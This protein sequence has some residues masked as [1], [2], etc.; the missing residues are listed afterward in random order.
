VIAVRAKHPRAMDAHRIGEAFSKQKVDAEIGGSV[1]DAI[2][3]AMADSDES[4][5]ICITGSLFVAAEARE[6]FGLTHV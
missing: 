5:L 1:R 2:M 6:H 4:G 3:Q